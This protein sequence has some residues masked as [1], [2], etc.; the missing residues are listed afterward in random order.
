MI[1]ALGVAA[2]AFALWP[3]VAEALRRPVDALLQAEA[4]GQF[5]E[6]KGG[7]THYHWDGPEGGPVIVLIHGLSSPSYV[8]EGVVPGLCNLGFRVLRYDLLGRGYS[9]RFSGRVSDQRYVEQLND[10]L[11]AL[12]VSGRV[13]LIGYSMGARIASDYVAKD[14]ERVQH[15]CL[16]APAGM[17]HHLTKT[18]Q[19]ARDIPV[20]GDW[21]ARGF[22]L[23]KYRAKVQAQDGGSTV[24]DMTKRLLAETHIR[25]LAPAMLAD[26]RDVL[27]D[28]DVAEHQRI[29]RAAVPVAAVFGAD[30]QVIPISS[31][32]QLQTWNPEADTWI[33]DGAG[34]SLPHTHPQSVVEAFEKLSDDFL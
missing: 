8:W 5:V 4:S 13:S 28:T 16:V 31:A 21:F 18:E 9:D 11:S 10:L 20:F 7:A 30:D 32:G 34:H 24:P 27:R 23:L 22:G 19:M 17:T 25:G 15:L 14:A 3:F 33:I 29:A 6:L 12:E 26:L 1:W 2:I